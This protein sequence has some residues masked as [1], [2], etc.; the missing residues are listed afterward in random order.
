MFNHLYNFYWYLR[1]TRNAAKKRR[2][3]RYVKQEKK[4]LEKLGANT[5]CLRL[6][7]RHLS[8]LKNGQAEKRY[9]NYRKNCKL[10]R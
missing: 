6:F 7:C 3:Y 5:E 1:V 2:Y 8:N 9:M 4:R 10:C